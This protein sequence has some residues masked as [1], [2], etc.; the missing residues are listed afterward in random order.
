MSFLTNNRKS[1]E[2]G[3]AQVKLVAIL[4]ALFLVGYAAYNYIPIA[5]E[6]ESFKQD[7]QTAVVQG[8][9]TPNGMTMTDMVKGKLQK[10]MYSNNIP[11]DAIVQITQTSNSVQAHV[12]YSKKVTM[13]PFGLYKY[14]YNFDYTAT[15]TGFLMKQ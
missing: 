13:L 4:V 3:S 14:N 11:P 6:G 12:T 15:P 9:A 7:M 5:Y 2:T 10:A 8:M 1:S